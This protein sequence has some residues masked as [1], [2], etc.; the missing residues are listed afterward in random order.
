MAEDLRAVLLHPHWS[1]AR[2]LGS[3]RR[4]R[5]AKSRPCTRPCVLCVTKLKPNHVYSIYRLMAISPVGFTSILIL[6]PTD[7][8]AY[9][10]VEHALIPQESAGIEELPLKS[11]N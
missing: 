9:V 6:V 11:V 4:R 1:A 2:L 8:W 5:K 10:M 7:S 3:S